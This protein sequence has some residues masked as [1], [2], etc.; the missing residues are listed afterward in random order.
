[1]SLVGIEDATKCHP[2][3][4]ARDADAGRFQLAHQ[5]GDRDAGATDVPSP[6]KQIGRLDELRAEECVSH[7]SPQFHDEWC[8]VAQP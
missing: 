2:W 3:I 7:G 8:V 4:V 6:S 1:M 5:V